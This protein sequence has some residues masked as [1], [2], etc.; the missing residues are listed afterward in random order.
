MVSLYEMS[1]RRRTRTLKTG[2]P[3]LD[4]LLPGCGVYD[5]QAVPGCMAQYQTV[6]AMMAE[7]LH[8]S[9]ENR[10][11]SIDT[12]N[13]FPFHLLQDHKMFDRWIDGDGDQTPPRLLS[14]TANSM[15]C[16][17]NC[18]MSDPQI[19]QCSL[20]IVNNFHELVELYRHEVSSIHEEA[21]LKHQIVVNSTFQANLAKF[22]EEGTFPHLP[23]LPAQSDLLKETPTRRF[24]THMNL[25]MAA[26][27]SMVENGSTC[28]LLVG[29]LDT[30]RVSY[31]NGNAT[32]N[33]VSPA[34]QDHHHHPRG[35]GLSS[36]MPQTSSELSSQQ[37]F[38]LMMTCTTL[39]TS[40]DR[41]LACRMLYYKEI[42][43]DLDVETN[44]KVW[45][46]QEERTGEVKGLRLTV[47]GIDR[48]DDQPMTQTQ[49]NNHTLPFRLPSSPNFTDSQR[50]EFLDQSVVMEE[51]VPSSSPL[52]NISS[53]SSVVEASDEDDEL[54]DVVT[55]QTI[56]PC[57]RPLDESVLE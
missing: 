32:M 5:I 42:T 55:Y 12:L 48:E 51:R 11:V 9:P 4:A 17:Y 19:A 31:T 45:N 10:V 8:L 25:L 6:A 26:I 18:L 46:L 40:F 24:N 34:V 7:H 22:K 23:K 36:P 44:V 27:S 37:S 53:Q 2:A 49:E 13:P 3:A 38:R 54:L 30:K 39:G 50:R 33:R 28:C 21:L 41:Y 14:L 15:S 57:I 52:T 47:G 56:T 20:L 43:T 16:L 29:Y 1:Q 35:M